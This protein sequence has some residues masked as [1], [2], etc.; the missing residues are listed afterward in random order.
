MDETGDLSRGPLPLRGRGALITGVSRRA[1][2]GHAIACR[3]AALGAHVFVHHYAPHDHDQDWGVDD[4]DA[5]L[6][7]VRSH[8]IDD[9]VLADLHADLTE[10]DAPHRVLD[11]AVATLGHIDI[12]VCN[13]ALSGEDGTLG[14]LTAAGL[15]RHFAVNTR[16]SILLTQAFVARHDGR[17]G[18][19]V[20]FMTSGQGLGPMPGEV[21]YAAAKAALGGITTTLADEIADS[22]IRLNTVNPGPVDTGY[23]TEEMWHQTAPMFPF[24]RFGQPDDP[25]RLISWLV[26]DEA[27]WITG[28]VLNTEG[29]FGRWRPRG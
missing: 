16:S 26:T 7:S 27:R 15:D 28:Q 25:A 3:L 5:V 24:G 18:G 13:H 12:L 11:N 14:D 4:L 9:A 19:A 2:I 8:L 10:P 1:G 23:L 20:V 22:G 6:S 21:C 17:A 29:G